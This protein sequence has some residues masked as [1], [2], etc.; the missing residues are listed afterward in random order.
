MTALLKINKLMAHLDANGA[1]ESKS[2]DAAKSST[3]AHQISDVKLGDIP[4][5][6]S[7][8]VTPKRMHFLQDG[9]QRKWDLVESMGAV[10]ALCYH[11]EKRSFL[12]VKQFRAPVY[13]QRMKEG[14]LNEDED[15]GSGHQV[16]CTVELIAGLKDKAELSPV[17][18]VHEELI[19]EVGYKVPVKD[20]EFISC[21]R[22]AVGILGTKTHIFFA[23]IDES[24]RVGDGGGCAEENELIELVWIPVKESRKFVLESEDIPPGLKFAVYWFFLEHPELCKDI[25]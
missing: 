18:T 21:Y 24:M 4:N 23:K 6:K 2:D 20:I 25:K 19:E 22:S 1:A 17:E 9:N 3:V 7:R 15:K 11:A 16:G 12:F 10:A 14:T 8:F 5:G 13:Y